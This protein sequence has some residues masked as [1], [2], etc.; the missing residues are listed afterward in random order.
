MDVCLIRYNAGNCASVLNALGRIGAHAEVSDDPAVLRA[1]P[2]V[3]FP[4]VGEAASAMAHLRERGLD[5]VI[6]SLTQ[7]FLGICLGLQ[8]LCEHS[9][10]RDTL[11]LGVF[12]HKVRRYRP[13]A[14]VK[15][16]HLGWNTVTQTVPGSPLTTGTA[17]PVHFYY[18]NGYR[19]DVGPCTVAT[20]DHGGTFSAMLAKGNFFAAQFHPEKSATAGQALLARFLAMPGGAA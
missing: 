3:I 17:A 1:A 6:R 19:A 15:V 16:P 13:A 2:R 11:C 10:E 4:G 20:T 8:L 9:E 5:Q 7:P 14:G 12:P 18:L